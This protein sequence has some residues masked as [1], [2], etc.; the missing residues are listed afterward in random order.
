MER[1]EIAALRTQWPVCFN[2]ILYA[3]K[4]FP[5]DKKTFVRK[6]RSLATSPRF[7]YAEV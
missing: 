1:L 2:Y 4:N 3:A 5:E 7:T 6:T